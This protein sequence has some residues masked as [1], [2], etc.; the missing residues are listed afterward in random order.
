MQAFEVD[1]QG[2]VEE[3]AVRRFVFFCIFKRGLKLNL[4]A[5]DTCGELH[6]VIL[7][8]PQKNATLLSSFVS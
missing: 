1:L 3:P 7:F 2:N 4:L 5:I 8:Q 6:A